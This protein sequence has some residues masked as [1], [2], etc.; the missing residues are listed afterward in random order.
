MWDDMLVKSRRM[1]YHIDD[2]K[3]AFAT[4]RKFQIKLN[5]AKY[6]FGVISRKFFSFMVL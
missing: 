5:P 3:E 1:S 4:L 2:L 6:T